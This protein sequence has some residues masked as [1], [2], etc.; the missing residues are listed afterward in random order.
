MTTLAV[1]PQRV[2]EAAS[3]RL[4]AS[5]YRALAK[6]SCA[7]GSGVLRLSGC[8]PSYYLKQMAQAAVAGLEGVERVANE[9]AVVST[10]LRVLIVEDNADCAEALALL[11]R[12]DGHDVDTAG[13]GPTG[14]E[15]ARDDEPDV[16]LLDLGLPGMSGLDVA[17]RLR[18]Q[19]AWRKAPLLIAVTG[20]GQE[21]DRRRSAEAGIDLHLVKPVDPVQLRSVLRRF[22][23]VVGRGAGSR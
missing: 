15:K 23:D 1:R 14:L 17:R 22:Y 16:V 10:S 5:P 18:E 8:L 20:H 21:A 7:Y 6:V 13:D 12:L 11:L 19:G 4:R 2:E 9:V 3:G